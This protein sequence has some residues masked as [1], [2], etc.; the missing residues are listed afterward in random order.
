MSLL[1]SAVTNNKTEMLSVILC[2]LSH[3]HLVKISYISL[4]PFLYS[5]NKFKVLWTQQFELISGLIMKML[6][7]VKTLV[8][9][10]VLPWQGRFCEGSCPQS[11]LVELRS[12]FLD[13]LCQL[14]LHKTI[15]QHVIKT[16]KERRPHWGLTS[17]VYEIIINILPDARNSW[18][19]NSGLEKQNFTLKK[20]NHHFSATYFFLDRLFILFPVTF[21][22]L[23]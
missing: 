2:I 23:D 22:V 10:A 13:L 7:L 8:G 9:R 3:T 4:D 5:V 11:E 12:Q 1:V 6:C 15:W 17:S 18:I 21:G 20:Y 19:F 14:W 16:T